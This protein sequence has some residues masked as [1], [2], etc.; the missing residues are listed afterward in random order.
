MP[1][2]DFNKFVKQLNQHVNNG[3]ARLRNYPG[4]TSK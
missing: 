2:C 1:N 3:N 4:A